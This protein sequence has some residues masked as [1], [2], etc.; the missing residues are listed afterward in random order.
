MHIGAPA[1]PVV[2]VGDTVKV[3]QLIAE[4]DG[5][6]SS[7]V[8]SGVS[9]KVKKIDDLLMSAG[10]RVPA[11]VIETDGEQAGSGAFTAPCVSDF[12]TFIGAVRQ[13]GVVGLGGAGFPTAVKLDVAD[14]SKLE[15]IIVNGAECEPY[16]TSDTRTMI[17][18]AESVRGGV[19]LLREYMKAKDIVI[20]VEKNKPRCIKIFSEMFRD[21]GHVRVAALPAVYPQGAEK[22]LIY[23]T[24]GRL[25]P[26]GGLPIDIGVIVINCTTLAAIEKYI[27][28][29]TP[30]YEKCV[31]VDGSAVASP[32][33]VIVPIGT[34]L[35]DVFA[36]CGGFSE[37]PGKVLYG[38]PMM[39]IAVPDLEQ[40]VLKNTNAVLAL[41]AREAEPPEET[42]CI[43][44]GRCMA[45]CPLRL[46]PAEIE[47]AYRRNRPDELEALRVG[48]C[49]ECGC[50]AYVCPANRHLVQ[51][52]KLSKALLR[53]Y[54]AVK[55][56][57]KEESA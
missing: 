36:F 30:L 14:L 12:A 41:S 53:S 56:A 11:V 25:V 38:G 10:Q 15:T 35:R 34:P 9:G 21:D 52:N 1:R 27:R 55:P 47:S 4:A 37:R 49:M 43:R 51:T 20:A 23:N 50:C 54:R 46:S 39:G 5:A 8:Y 48:L 44:C 18:D 19:M 33:N 6:M 28:T 45:R 13:S 42:A 32:G 31:T 22:V 29:G 26:E 24:T 57:V 3:G 2:Q 7:P 40:T 17:D 16:I